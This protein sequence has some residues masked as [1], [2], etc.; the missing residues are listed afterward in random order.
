MLDYN[1]DVGQQ[2]YKQDNGGGEGE[3]EQLV[4]VDTSQDQFGRLFIGLSQQG[5]LLYFFIEKE[6]MVHKK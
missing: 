2:C 1:A 6:T 5:E 3:R 4:K